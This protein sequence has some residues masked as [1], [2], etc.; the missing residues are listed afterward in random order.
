MSYVSVYTEPN[1]D[2]VVIG[3]YYELSDART[4]CQ[5]HLSAAWESAIGQ[6]R[7]RDTRFQYDRGVFSQWNGIPRLYV[8][9]PNGEWAHYDIGELPH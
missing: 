7:F 2:P 4:A 8:T 6:D 9:V 3:E 5:S 1:A